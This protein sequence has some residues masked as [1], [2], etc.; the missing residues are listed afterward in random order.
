MSSQTVA[1]VGATIGATTGAISLV[2]QWWSNRFKI[3]FERVVLRYEPEAVQQHRGRSSQQLEKSFFD[4]EV[5]LE[6]LNRASGRGS[7][8]KP[9]L[10]LRLPSGKLMVQYPDTQA[11]RSE[12]IDG[13]PGATRIWIERWG[14][15]YSIAPRERLDDALTYVVE[16]DGGDE[17][18]EFLESF[19]EVC[20]TLL[21]RDH[22][23]RERRSGIS[24]LVGVEELI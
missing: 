22:R 14:N 13:H 4:F 18:Q 10:E 19:D 3:A 1:I 24:D 21:Y 23:G 12:P 16:F 7:I 20:F 17:F 6:I 15:S 5:E 2:S 8:E 11:R 9:R